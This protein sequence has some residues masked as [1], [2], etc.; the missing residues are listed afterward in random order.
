MNPILKYTLARFGLFAAS[1]VLVFLVVPT[2][3]NPLLKLLIA[4]LISAAGSFFLL[5]RWR[6][7]VA[8]QLAAGATRRQVE[9]E[10]LRSAL[11]GEDEEGTPPRR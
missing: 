10:R 8:G 6:D 3:V 7:D 11:A 2:S 5:R 4:L 9:K 1:A